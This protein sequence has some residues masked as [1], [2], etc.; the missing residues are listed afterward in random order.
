MKRVD[1]ETG[2][3]TLL[4]FV[5]SYGVDSHCEI[6]CAGGDEAEAEMVGE[7]TLL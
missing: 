5:F 2:E 4:L 1:N 6:N 7:D 3:D